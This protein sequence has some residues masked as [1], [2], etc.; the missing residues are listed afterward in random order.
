MV[1][2]LDA[3]VDPRIREARSRGLLHELHLLDHE[4]LL[5]RLLAAGLDLEARDKHE[6]TPLLSAVHWGGSPDLVRALMAAGARIDVIDEMEMSLSQEIRRYKRTDL[7]FL[8][9][10]VDEEFPG[11]GADWFDEHMEYREEEDEDDDA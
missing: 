6:R 2:L 10:R 4:A 5:P 11:I 1:A 8:R 3:G 7:T 9:E